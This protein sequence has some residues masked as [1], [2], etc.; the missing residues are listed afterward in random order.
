M[1]HVFN[2]HIHIHVAKTDSRCTECN[3][4]IE[5]GE[6]TFRDDRQNIEMC[7]ECCGGIE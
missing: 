1:E 7:K 2:R 6:T 5:R 3:S 4:E